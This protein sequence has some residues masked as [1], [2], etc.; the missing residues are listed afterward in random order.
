MMMPC[1]SSWTALWSTGTQPWATSR[2]LFLGQTLWATAQQQALWGCCVR[3]SIVTGRCLHPWLTATKQVGRARCSALCML[4]R[5]KH[6]VSPAGPNQPQSSAAPFKTCGQL[7]A[8]WDLLDFH[9]RD[10]RGSVWEAST[11]AVESTK[12]PMGRQCMQ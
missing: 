1:R 2:S 9:L 6:L 12:C 3:C 7:R 5:L 11:D 8:P 4:A 10:S